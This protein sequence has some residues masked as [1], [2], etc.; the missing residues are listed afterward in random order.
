M[1]NGYGKCILAWRFD[2]EYVTLPSRYSS[3]GGKIYTGKEEF[4]N[5]NMVC[6]LQK[7]LY[8]LK[9][10]L[11]QWFAKLTTTLKEF[12]Y[13]QSKTNYSVF[14]KLTHKH[15]LGVLIHVDELLIAGNVQQAITQ[16]KK[17]L[18]THFLR[19]DLGDIRYFLGIEIGRSKKGLFLSQKKYTKDLLK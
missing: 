7:S 3:I 2:G 11:R 18:F 19:K 9:Q 4:K 13:E 12:E 10:D 17:I 5:H 14:I 1:S 8:G 6:K 16:T 15:F